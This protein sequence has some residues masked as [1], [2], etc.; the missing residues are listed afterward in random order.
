[1]KKTLSILFILIQINNL[2][3]QIN[4]DDIAFE[5]RYPIPVGDNFL[6]KGLGDGYHGIVDIGVDYNFIKINN[7]G[8]GI[9][10]NSS[11][12]SLSETDL[13]LI[14]LNP[15]IKID[16][17]IN[18][19]KISIIP[20]IAIGYS[21]WR[22]R[23]PTMTYE[24]ENPAQGEK[25]KENYD[26]LSFEWASKVVLNSNNRLNWYL[27]LDYE[28]T[29]LE[30]TEKGADLKYNRNIHI[31]YPGIGLLWKFNKK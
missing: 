20:N 21:N 27:N 28:F 24:Y 11:I 7:F 2:L 14:I 22:F 3:A 16:Y 1:M 18:I 30:K 31:L 6:N 26:G 25:F 13:T 4:K 8:I 19:N 9:L 12:L 17:K 5:L 29:K 23:A 15:K 10:F